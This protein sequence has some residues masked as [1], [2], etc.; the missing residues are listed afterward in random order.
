M[1]SLV[2]SEVSNHPKW[3]HLHGSDSAGS[4]GGMYLDEMDNTMSL[5]QVLLSSGCPSTCSGL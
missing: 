4:S 2:P 5:A 3:P 1:L